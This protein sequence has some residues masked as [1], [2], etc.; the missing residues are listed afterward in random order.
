MRNGYGRGWDPEEKAREATEKA[1]PGG[2][3]EGVGVVRRREE[4]MKGQHQVEVW[5]RVGALSG[6]C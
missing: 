4:H 6:V 2:E 1:A 3:I 5:D